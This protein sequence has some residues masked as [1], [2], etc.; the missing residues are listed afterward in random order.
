MVLH[1]IYLFEPS[2]VHLFYVVLFYWE[3]RL[4]QS[5]NFK[6]SSFDRWLGWSIVLFNR[7]IQS[8]LLQSKGLQ[9]LLVICLLV[10]GGVKRALRSN[11]VLGKDRFLELH[12]FRG[13]ILR[14]EPVGL[15]DLLVCH[16]FL[17][18]LFQVSN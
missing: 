2:S 5:F 16:P 7:H 17:M 11:H 14:F 3:L 1:V 4:L 9:R 8:W 12:Y 6:E 18:L 13:F 15:P 10:F